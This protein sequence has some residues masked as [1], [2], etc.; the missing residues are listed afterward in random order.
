[1]DAIGGVGKGTGGG[2]GRS[3]GVQEFR[4]SGVQ[5]FKSLGVQEFKSSG[6]EFNTE[7]AEIGARR[8]Q[9]RGTQE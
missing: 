6:K 5:E 9:R 8:A 3:S 7:F 1:L 4:S 2:G